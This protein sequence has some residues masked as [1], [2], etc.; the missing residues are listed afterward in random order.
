MAVAIV[1][2]AVLARG[3]AGLTTS[4][5]DVSASVDRAAI[6]AQPDTADRK[7]PPEVIDLPE[8]VSQ[9][10]HDS[11]RRLL[12]SS[13]RALPGI[14]AAVVVLSTFWVLAVVV[15]HFV[16]KGSRYVPDP[17][18]KHLLVQAAYYFTWLV[19]FIVAL[20]V[21]GVNPEAVI[22]ALGLTGV[23]VG[24]ALRDVIENLVSGLLILGT[25]TFHIGDQ[26]E[27]G[28]LEGSVEAIDL[29]AT[30]I[31]TFDGR[32]M[33]VPNGQVLSSRVTN[34][35]ASPLRRASIFVYFGYRDDVGRLQS[36]V[37]DA[38]GNL[39][40]TVTTPAPAIRLDLSPHYIRLEAL[41]WTDSRLT[42]YA[43]LASTARLAILDALTKAGV[44][45]SLPAITVAA[46]TSG[47][48]RA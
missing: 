32:L 33:L 48:V 22:T 37:L 2:L 31:R 10:L 16:R 24:F 46:P 3:P 42:D 39:S 27:V 7:V 20:D 43:T 8:D 12:Q 26:I 36:I 23:A 40:G 15:R 11:F 17:T 14:I 47:A 25:R 6:A 35:T 4:A 29:R 21:V 9:S 30:H 28:D 45:L 44:E 34:I 13:V 38:V 5:I 1:V 19:G 41:F 18:T